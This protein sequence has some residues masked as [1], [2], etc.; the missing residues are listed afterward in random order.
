MIFPI[1]AC[2]ISARRT[3]AS[4]GSWRLLANLLALFLAALSCSKDSARPP[5]QPKVPSPPRGVWPIRQEG[6]S[7]STNGEVAYRD[8]GVVYVY[9]GGG[10]L[11][12]DSLEGIW[13]VNSTSGQKRHITSFGYNPAWSPDARTIAFESGGQIFI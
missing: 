9:P 13:I 8:N 5:L 10:Y 6:P 3:G 7:W 11:T 4:R 2:L 1:S 12:S